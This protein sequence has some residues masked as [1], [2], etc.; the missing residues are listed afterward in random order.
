MPSTKDCSECTR[1][2]KTVYHAIDFASTFGVPTRLAA[3][4]IAIF[5][6]KAIL[7]PML[8]T[9]VYAIISPFKSNEVRTAFE[10]VWHLILQMFFGI[11]A[12]DKESTDPEV[13]KTVCGAIAK[14]TCGLMNCLVD[15]KSAEKDCFS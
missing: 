5:V 8:M 11:P 2:E 6:Y 12:W 7:A 15:M 13:P 1:Q 9:V 3:A 4:V 10:P 14:G